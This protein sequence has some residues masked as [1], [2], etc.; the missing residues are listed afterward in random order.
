MKKFMDRR[1]LDVLPDLSGNEAKIFMILFMK[2]NSSRGRVPVEFQLPQLAEE[3]FQTSDANNLRKLAQATLRLVKRGLIS[4]EDGCGLSS[5]PGAFF[6]KKFRK[7]AGADSNRTPL[8]NKLRFKI[9]K[10]AGFRCEY[11]GADSSEARL[12]VDHVL[13]VSKGGTNRESNLVAACDECNIGKGAR[14]L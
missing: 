1:F 4:H 5:S 14:L 10:R 11:C 9:L 7:R 8:P 3:Y 6:V 13:P 12:V 2:A